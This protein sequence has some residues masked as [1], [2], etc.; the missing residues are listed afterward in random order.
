MVLRGGPDKPLNSN[1]GT[2]ESSGIEEQDSLNSQENSEGDST[3]I[4]DSSNQN[5]K[6]EQ[7]NIDAQTDIYQAYDVAREKVDALGITASY[8]Y[9]SKWTDA[10]LEAGELPEELFGV[11]YPAISLRVNEAYAD[12]YA[13]LEKTLAVVNSIY[14]IDG[15]YI[16]ELYLKALQD[17]SDYLVAQDEADT[18][19]DTNS[20]TDNGNQ[21]T[22]SSEK[23][24]EN[25]QG[26][27]SDEN[28]ESELNRDFKENQFVSYSEE[29]KAY[30]CRADSIVLSILFEEKRQ[31]E[32]SEL[33]GV[34][35][36]PISGDFLKLDAIVKNMDVFEK[37]ACKIFSQTYP[38]YKIPTKMSEP[39]AWAIVREGIELYFLEE[40]EH[41]KILVPFSAAPEDD[42]WFRACFLQSPERTGRTLRSEED[43]WIDTNA[44]GVLE[45]LSIHP[46]SDDEDIIS[47]VD[48]IFNNKKTSLEVNA[49]GIESSM[50]HMDDGTFLYITYTNVDSHQETAIYELTSKGAIYRDTFGLGLYIN[51][52][53]P[54]L[55]GTEL[56]TNLEDVRFLS[57]SD[58][59]SKSTC[60]Q[61]YDIG[62]NGLPK[63]VS[64]YVYY[65]DGSVFVMKDAL[66]VELVDEKTGKLKEEKR[67]LEIG[68]ELQAFRTDNKTYVD[69]LLEDGAVC[70]I[71]V[72]FMEE[73]GSRRVNGS[74]IEDLFEGDVIPAPKPAE[75]TID[76]ILNMINAMNEDEA[77]PEN[78]FDNNPEYNP[79]N[80]IENT[81]SEP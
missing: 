41:L 68:D 29:T 44:D 64:D 13:L 5:G 2:I 54:P 25:S 45:V 12:E 36:D 18:D 77:N 22:N 61:F 75:P 38:K 79:E 72:L 60:W 35:I 21:D 50:L 37:N 17:Y 56:L 51:E 19:S 62:S 15:G 1:Q 27:F 6:E 66:E 46:H 74:L 3:D 70:R 43:V 55:V 69:L 81:P 24:S 16:D 57:E 49:L 76:E 63:A 58:Y 14:R 7:N 59:F 28:M 8:N 42:V 65:L 31:G 78:G 39:D 52:D 67:L 80:S 9:I 34:T 48:L 11:Q 26:A 10:R 71:R 47:N 33:S 20:D 53:Y 23:T 30:I 32:P 40:E 73:D 4:V